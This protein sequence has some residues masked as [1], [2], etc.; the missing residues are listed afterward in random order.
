MLDKALSTLLKTPT[1]RSLVPQGKAA[2]IAGI[3]P[4]PSH[5]FPSRHSLPEGLRG[6][7][8]RKGVRLLLFPLVALSPNLLSR[9]AKKE[10]SSDP[11]QLPWSLVTRLSTHSFLIASSLFLYQRISPGIRLSHCTGLAGSPLSCT[12]E[13]LSQ[14]AS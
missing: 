7:E 13:S 1:Q 12:W 11:L 6:K 2:L 9:H 14:P 4:L 10:D 5:S 3:P 8:E